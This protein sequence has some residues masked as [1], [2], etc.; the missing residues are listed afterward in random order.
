LVNN[1]GIVRDRLL[2]RMRDEDWDDVLATNLRGTF[3]CTRAVLH[4][5]VR[6]RF[7]RIVSIGSVAGVVGNA[8]Q[9]NYSAA[10]A[11]LIG[12][13][14]A[15]AREIA[16]RDITVNVVAPGFITTEIWEGV[17]DEAKQRFLAAVPQG[18]PGTPEDVAHVVAF[19]VGPEAGY[20][21]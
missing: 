20:I 16:S 2:L 18:R 4:G 7:G 9:A 8:G 21:T 11:G 13:T 6:Q 1:A 14:R 15:V 12:F 17:S 19:L 5:M 3:L 10:K